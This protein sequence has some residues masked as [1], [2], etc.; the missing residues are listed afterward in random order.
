MTLKT[1]KNDRPS[2]E[3]IRNKATGSQVNNNE[4]YKCKKCNLS[5]IARKCPAYGKVCNICGKLNHYAVGCKNKGLLQQRVQQRNVQDLIQE[6]N[7]EE[8]IEILDVSSINNDNATVWYEKIKLDDYNLLKFKLDTGSQVNL[9]PYALY[10]Q[11]S[12]NKKPKSCNI[13]LRAYGGQ[14]IVPL[15]EVELNACINNK[16]VNLNFIIIQEK[17]QPILGLD[18]CV[19]LGLIKKVDN[20]NSNLVISNNKYSNKDMFIE[21]NADVF[22]GLGLFPD[23]YK[24]K[25]DSNAEG[26]IRPPRRL[27]QTLAVKLE[28]ELEELVK[29]KIIAR[30]KEPEKW[31]SNIIC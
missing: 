4:R 30:V 12:I 27:P 20:V 31:S 16:N 18:G 22:N 13:V 26:I 11:M 8:M 21:N 15:F 6:D 3:N 5:H 7:L 9:I 25:I 17:A 2:N 29:N 10:K 28:K 1:N 14:K 19:K 23:T 24:I